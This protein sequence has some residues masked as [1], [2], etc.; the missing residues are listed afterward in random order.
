MLLKYNQAR[1][2][3]FEGIFLTPGLNDVA[4]EIVAAMQDD[5]I[6]QAKFDSK[7]IEIVDV[8]TPPRAKS[9]RSSGED[10]G[11]H[12]KLKSLDRVD[13]VEAIEKTADLTL[14]QRWFSADK[15]KTVREAIRKQVK[16]IKNPEYREPAGEDTLDTEPEKHHKEKDED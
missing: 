9:S 2:L 4:P 14:L 1:V 6:M 16:R 7:Q 8:E 3:G 5:E 13:A 11:I 10:D 12:H 15:R